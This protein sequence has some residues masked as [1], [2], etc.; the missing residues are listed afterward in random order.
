M[1]LSLS[2]EHK[3]HLSLLVHHDTTVVKEFCR[4]ATQFVKHG[5]NHRVFTSAATKLG[6]L[7]TQ[8]EDAIK[9]LVFLLSHCTQAATS[10]SEFQELTISLGFNE[11]AVSVLTD[12]YTQHEVELKDYL[13]T[14]GV[15]ILQ[16]HNLEWRFDILVG[17]RTLS[18]IAEPLIT[19]ELS[20]DTNTLSGS[21]DEDGDGDQQSKQVCDKLL[22][23]ADPNNLVHM[24][25]IL[26]EALREAHTHHSRRIH[27]YLK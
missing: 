11:A 9:A 6:V 24:T 2:E 5:V 15:K 27:R 13:K 12:V 7:P 21:Q 26:E 10:Q 19:L 1:S 16:Y 23:Q 17:S 18:H 4:L 20:L 25:N 3:R 22:L 14:M 8:V